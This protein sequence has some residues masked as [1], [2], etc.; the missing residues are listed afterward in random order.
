VDIDLLSSEQYYLG[1][2]SRYLNYELSSSV[3]YFL[4]Y[5]GGVPLILAIIAATLFAPF[6]LFVLFRLR[7]TAWIVSFIIVVIL[8]F[9]I[10]I[11][12]GLK[13]GYL[14]AFILIPLGFF[15]FY[16]FILK[17]TVNEQLKEVSVR[18]ELIRKKVEEEQEKLLWQKQFKR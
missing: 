16:C 17:L 7:K 1:R 11:I 3:L 12:L 4:S 6:M 9:I 10:C 2:L 8:P 5:A 15:Y 18:E 14:S 13:V